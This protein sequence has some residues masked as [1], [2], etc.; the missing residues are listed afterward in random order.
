M[1]MP[2]ETSSTSPGIASTDMGSLVGERAMLARARARCPTFQQIC[3]DDLVCTERL[4]ERSPRDHRSWIAWSD[5]CFAS[6]LAA[7]SMEDLS[8][9]GRQ[10]P[11]ECAGDLRVAR[12]I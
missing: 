4:A 8:R 1:F 6:R 11:L 5:A 7:T 9:L 10:R 3:P 12:L 2:S